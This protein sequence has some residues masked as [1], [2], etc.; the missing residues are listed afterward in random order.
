MKSK[1]KF[2]VLLL[3]VLYAAVTVLVFNFY[4]DLALKDARQ[5]AFYVLDAMNGVRD[6]VS[7]IQRPLIE[8]L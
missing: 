5:E 1:F 2:I 4:R 7:T 6:Y 3:V 8:E